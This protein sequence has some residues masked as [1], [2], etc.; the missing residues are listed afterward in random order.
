M[1][2]ERLAGADPAAR[3]QPAGLAG[4]LWPVEEAVRTL[5]REKLAEVD[6][7]L[8]GVDAVWAPP[9]FDPFLVAQAL[10]IRCLPV[11][12]PW[13]DDAM[14]YVQDGRPTILY[15]PDRGA[16]RIRFSVFHEIAHTLFPDQLHRDLYRGT[17]RPRLFEPEGQLEC[18]CDLAAAEFLMPLDLFRADLERLGFGAAQ[19][20]ALV[21]VEERRRWHAWQERGVEGWPHCCWRGERRKRTPRWRRT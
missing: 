9:P 18:L 4:G 14:I 6:A 5:A 21:S 19:V 20:P 15:R 10:G 8:Q 1:G 12:T 17:A 11:Q 3:D 2:P 16:A 7:L 13:V